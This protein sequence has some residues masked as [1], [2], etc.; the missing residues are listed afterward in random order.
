MPL[1]F[2][3]R[4]AAILTLG[5]ILAF[6]LAVDAQADPI[7][8]VFVIPMENHNWIQPG[9][10]T[11]PGQIYGSPYA[12]YINSLVTPGNPNAAQVSYASNYQNA[13]AGIHPSEP[14]YI[15]A[16]A[17]SNLG[18]KND[19]DPYGPG[20][21][22]QTTSVYLHKSEYLRLSSDGKTTAFFHSKG[23]ACWL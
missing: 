13:A 2:T 10:E 1:S 20:S 16:E 11:S 6:V 19:N 17:G 14:N 5:G 3:H 7:S 12:P 23:A 4:R 22:N 9:S 8:T 18:V 15:W 21:T